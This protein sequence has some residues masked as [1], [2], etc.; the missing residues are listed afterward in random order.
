MKNKRSVTTHLLQLQKWP[1]LH[2]YISRIVDLR[3][4]NLR[5][6]LS[7]RETSDV[8]PHCVLL[9]G[10]IASL[11]VRDNIIRHEHDVVCIIKAAQSRTV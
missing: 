6:Y 10:S 9:Y 7:A 1:V 8:L 11:V 3:V 2:T 5:V 4:D